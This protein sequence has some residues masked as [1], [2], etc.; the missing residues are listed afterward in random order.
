M[1]RSE[2]QPESSEADK[3]AAESPEARIEALE[4][5]LRKAETDAREA[6]DQALRA[7]AELENARK[8]LARDKE[9]FSKFAS[10]AVLR[11][12]LPVM[13]SLAQA[14]L[15]ADE[16]ANS[17]AVVKGVHL[18]HRQLLGL[19]EQ[20]GM[21][22]IPTVGHRFDPHLHE[23]AA[24]VPAEEGQEDGAIVEELQVGYTMHGMVIRPA[25]VKVAVASLSE[26]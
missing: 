11:R 13:D 25:L 5:A 19:L 12:L 18:I 24:R 4:E 20:S 6:K 23:A 17:D 1:S 3:P 10:E 16:R 22:R 8:R 26:A 21:H 7:L 2:R 15:T 9:E 14:V